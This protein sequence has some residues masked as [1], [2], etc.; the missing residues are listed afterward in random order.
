MNEISST[1]DKKRYPKCG[2]VE[3][4]SMN[5]GKDNFK[6]AFES[7]FSPVSVDPMVDIL[8]SI[9]S[10]VSRYPFVNLLD[11]QMLLLLC[12]GDYNKQGQ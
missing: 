4:I 2:L 11:L 9:Q 12:P 5:Y 6:G 8:T 7:T 1:S 3:V 10:S